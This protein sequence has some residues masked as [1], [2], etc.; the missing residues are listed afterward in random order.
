MHACVHFKVVLSTGDH[1]A[2][3][4]TISRST[5][6]QIIDFKR[7]FAFLAMEVT[8][9]LK[10]RFP[11][12]ISLMVLLNDL[13]K[14]DLNE[15]LMIEQPVATHAELFLQLQ[16]K[17]IF[18]NPT[19]FQQLINYL[20]GEDLQQRMREYSQEYDSFCQSLKI[21]ES[22][23]QRGIHFDDYDTK[24]PCLIVIIE[25]GPLNFN[26]IYLFL[27]NVFGIYKRYLRLH[28]IEPGC[29]K[30]TLQFPPSITQLIQAC[31]DQKCEAV[32]RFA[33]MELKLPTDSKNLDLD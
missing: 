8:E 28:K 23:L 17:W 15:P 31:I 30:V 9:Y 16:K 1:K 27:D 5:Q 14:S 13:L 33:K 20:T 2:A 4:M 24:N 11:D 26:D 6:E 29:I 3:A 32:K 7:R 21:N 12:P 19:I 18:T 22:A 10:K 25:S